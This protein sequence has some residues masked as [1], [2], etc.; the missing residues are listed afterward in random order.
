MQEIHKERMSIQI[1]L[2]REKQNHQK[3]IDLREDIE[4]DHLITEEKKE[5][6]I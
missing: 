3:E 2:E 4:A 1:P 5:I 6:G